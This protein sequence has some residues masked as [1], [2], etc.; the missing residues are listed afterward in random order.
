MGFLF[1]RYPDISNGLPYLDE[2]LLK[3]TK[4]KA[5]RPDRII[6]YLLGYEYHDKNNLDTVGDYYLFGRLKNLGRTNLVKP[7][8]EVN[9]FDLPMKETEITI[10]PDGIKVLSGE[11]NMIEE[12]GIDDW[13]CGVQLDSS[14]GGLWVRDGREL[15][16]KTFLDKL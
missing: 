10:L 13:V 9:A 4:E 2:K 1:L 5:P 15:V 7:L 12:N 14:S 11:M 16:W 6:G 3:Y 8:V